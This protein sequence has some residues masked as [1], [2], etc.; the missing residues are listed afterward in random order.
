MKQLFPQKLVVIDSDDSG[1]AVAQKA[2]KKT[3]YF[4]SYCF[5]SPDNALDFIHEHAVRYV[6]ASIRLS[7]MT[8]EDLIQAFRKKMDY[9]IFIS[10][11]AG[12]D[13]VPMA[14]QCFN[15]GADIY[16]GTASAE[17]YRHITDS[18][19]EK[20]SNW[21]FC[22]DSLVNRHTKTSLL[23][24]T[25][26]S[27]DADKKKNPEKKKILLLAD[28]D[29]DI[30]SYM[31]E[32]LETWYR[33]IP[34]SNGAEALACSERVDLVITDL[35]MPEVDGFKLISSLKE[36]EDF[37]AS[38]IVV[39]GYAENHCD[40]GDPVR[41]VLNKPFDLEELHGI[42]EKIFSDGSVNS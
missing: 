10:F 13:D 12:P 35:N 39:S 9:G 40:F 22:I 31:Q 16:A 30:R 38:V 42:I 19:L 5:A 4:D 36:R 14:Y 8:A 41:A 26:R 29:E 17:L 23:T 2:L 11:L 6:I 15:L 3:A 18:F 1:R 27:E 21:N 32:Y 34:A 33:V 7:G 20:I 37:I 24:E 28:D 25:D